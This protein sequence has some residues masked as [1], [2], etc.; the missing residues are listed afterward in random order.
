MDYFRTNILDTI[1]DRK[2]LFIEDYKTRRRIYLDDSKD[3]ERIELPSA[4][5]VKFVLEDEGGMPSSP[6]V[7]NQNLKYMAGLKGILRGRQGSFKEGYYLDGR[8]D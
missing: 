6:S 1:G 4:N 8:K 3:E 7:L 2:V 5:V